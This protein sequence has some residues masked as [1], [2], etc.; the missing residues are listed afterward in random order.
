MGAK[1]LD[2]GARVKNAQYHPAFHPIHCAL[3]YNPIH[4]VHNHL[5]ASN[6]HLQ[7]DLD[8]IL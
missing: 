7:L 3:N 8:Q 2:F 1:V 6:I 4:I 5:L